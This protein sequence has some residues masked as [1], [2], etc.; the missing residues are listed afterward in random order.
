VRCLKTV[1]MDKINSILEKFLGFIDK[2]STIVIVIA[3]LAI[4]YKAFGNIFSFFQEKKEDKEE[5]QQ[6]HTNVLTSVVQ[7]VPPKT[8]DPKKEAERLAI[9][10]NNAKIQSAKFDA[11]C[12]EE[13]RKHTT[14]FAANAWELTPTRKKEL[15]RIAGDIQKYKGDM[16]NI[17]AEYKKAFND[18]LYADVRG[19]MG[20]DYMTWLN[21]CTKR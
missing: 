15:N 18:D 2:N 7:A 5:K 6:E 4:G 12:A 21:T 11:V 19:I 10:R 3:A 20:G 16:A 8:K 14:Y 1:G 9:I 17:A 13:I